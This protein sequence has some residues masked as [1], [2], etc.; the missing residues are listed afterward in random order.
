MSWGAT[1]ITVTFSPS[2]CMAHA[3]SSP[4][5]PPPMTAAVWACSASWR[6]LRA[7]ARERMAVTWGRLLPGM[8]GT[9]AL[10]AQG[11]DQPVIS[12]GQSAAAVH[13]SCGWINGGYLFA[14]KQENALL[15]IPAFGMQHQLAL[16]QGAG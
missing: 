5:T 14:G 8:G 1:S 11:V 7:S 2:C 16:I 10:S 6:T 4:S 13:F 3:A 12:H 15:R 9:K